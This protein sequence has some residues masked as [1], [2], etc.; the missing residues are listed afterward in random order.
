M[1]DHEDNEIFEIPP[2]NHFKVA[3]MYIDSFIL[4]LTSDE[5]KVLMYMIRNI[6]GRATWHH[7]SL[8]ISVLVN[9]RQLKET[10]CVGIGMKEGAVRKCLQSLV[11]YGFIEPLGRPT[12]IGQNWKIGSKIKIGE[13]RERYHKKLGLDVAKIQAARIKRGQGQ[14]PSCDTEPLM[15]DKTTPLLSDKTSEV[16][17]DKTQRKTEERQKRKTE[18]TSIASDDANVWPDSFDEDDVTY[19]FVE[20]RLSSSPSRGKRKTAAQPNDHA[21]DSDATTAPLQS[22]AKVSP[23]ARPS[24]R[25]PADTVTGEQETDGTSARKP[26]YPLLTII[27]RAWRRNEGFAAPIA[28]QLT[29]KAKKGERAQWK[30]D[31]PMTTEEIFAYRLWWDQTPARASSPM[32]VSSAEKLYEA[33]EEF[34]GDPRHDDFVRR[35]DSDLRSMYGLPQTPAPAPVVYDPIPADEWADVQRDL[36]KLFKTPGSA[37]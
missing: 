17:S 9:G 26:A 10:L 22:S 37:S 20:E 15:S 18:K 32:F 14:D 4:Y 31:P 28:A 30:V 23:R 5:F 27:A 29:G 12:S 21:E 3:N 33:I 2:D 25:P 13:L 19:P 36:D 16:L 1:A 11:K 35:A 7:H 6:T 34:R 8:A 24:A